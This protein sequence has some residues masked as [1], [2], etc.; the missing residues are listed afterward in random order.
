M[1]LTF[2]ALSSVS[3][4]GFYQNGT[5]RSWVADGGYGFQ[6]WRVAANILNKHSRTADKGRFSS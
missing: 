4:V 2:S 6:M 3:C 5:A 1:G